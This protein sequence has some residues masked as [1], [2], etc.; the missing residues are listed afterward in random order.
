MSKINMPEKLSADRG[1]HFWRRITALWPLKLVLTAFVNVIFWS[2]YLFLSRHSL[3]PIHALPMTWLDTWAG[4]QPSAWVWIYESI[5]LLTGVAPWLIDSREELRR[6]ISGFALLSFVSFAG[7]A[8][9]PV[10]S[11][12]PADLGANTFLIFIT[13]LDGPLNAFPSLHAGCLV[14]TLALIRRLFGRPLNSIAVILLLVWAGLILFGTL[15]TKQ[16]YA[17]D[18]LA[19][20]LLGGLADWFAWRTSAGGDNA[21]TKI[22]RKSEAA[23]HAG[24]R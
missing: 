20:G 14:Y 8:I 17:L 21:S 7:F 12:R 11:P 15:A 19:G 24:C 9:F 13:R 5:F 3:F 4:F 6:Y 2:C 18:L 1:C 10:A 16:H 23:S 22:R